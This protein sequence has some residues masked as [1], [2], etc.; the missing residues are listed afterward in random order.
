MRTLWNCG[1]AKVRAVQDIEE[2]GAELHIETLRN[3]PD[4]IV[5]ED[6]EIEVNQ[7]RPRDDV[8]PGISP[9]VETLKERR[10]ADVSIAIRIIE[11]LIRGC[12]NSETLRLNVIIGVSWSNQ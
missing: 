10:V 4:G 5:L 11:R 3:S 1:L 12:G 8:A 2:C 9:K 6:R 7:A